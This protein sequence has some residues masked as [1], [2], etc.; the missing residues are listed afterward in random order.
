MVPQILS[1]MDT[2]FCH[3]TIFLPFY[4]SNS[5]KNQNLKKCKKCLEISSFYMS[6][7]KIM[8]ICYSLSEIW[9]LTDVI[10]IFHFRLFLHFYPLNSP[11]NQNLKQIKKPRR[12]HHFTYVHQKLLSPM[13]GLMDRKDDIKRRVRPLKIAYLQYL[14]TIFV[15]TGLPNQN[16]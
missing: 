9:H 12:Y 5:L 7:P 13:D 15:Y 16:I 10:V 1:T 3:W 8:I 2:N 4:L 6:I 14:Q 11:K